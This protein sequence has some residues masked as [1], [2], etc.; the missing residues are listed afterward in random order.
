MLF[1]ILIALGPTKIRVCVG[2]LG[3]PSAA[4]STGT[5]IDPFAGEFEPKPTRVIVFATSSC[6]LNVMMFGCAGESGRNTAAKYRSLMPT[7]SNG[8][9]TVPPVETF[10]G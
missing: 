10:L 6:R 3:L 4:P 7:Q 2:P 5:F 9:S 8:P 1:R